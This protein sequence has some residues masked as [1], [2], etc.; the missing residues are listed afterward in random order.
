M[1]RMLLP[2]NTLTAASRSHGAGSPESLQEAM[3][4]TRTPLFELRTVGG[5]FCLLEAR[6]AINSSQ[7]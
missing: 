1:A 6:K 7:R 4:P 2:I 3:P 5:F